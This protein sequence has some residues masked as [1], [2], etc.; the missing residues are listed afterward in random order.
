MLS[1]D[2]VQVD[3]TASCDWLTRTFS[4][5]KIRQFVYDDWQTATSI[6]TAEG[7]EPSAWQWMGYDGMSVGGLSWGHR[8]DTD[9][10]RASGGTAERMFDRFGHYQG[11]CSRI[12]IALTLKWPTPQRHTASKAYQKVTG[13]VDSDKRRSYSLVVNSRGGETLYVGSRS[14]NQFG[15]LYD[16]DAESG[17][18]QIARRWR[19]EVEFKA[20]RAGKVLE[21]LQ[22]TRDRGKLYLGIVQGFFKPRGVSMPP[23]ADDALVR[24]EII[25]P[26][27]QVDTQLAWLRQQVAPVVGRLQ[28]LGLED[29][30][31]EALRL[32]R[33]STHGSY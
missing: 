20:D 4:N 14:S 30:V 3:A 23:L 6:L 10:L 12:D 28:R 5:P 16:K 29:A 15:R 26:P 13:G 11:N 17:L 8:E 22:S 7:H 27:K 33:V 18:A 1:S 2:S 25:E 24:V 9:I 19:Y 21:L 31:V 32:E